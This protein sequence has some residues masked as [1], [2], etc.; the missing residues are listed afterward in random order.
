MG[1]TEPINLMTT[2]L[3]TVR[4]H[5]VIRVSLRAG[6]RW[7]KTARSSRTRRSRQ[8]TS[9]RG[10]G[11]RVECCRQP[12]GDAS[13]NQPK[14]CTTKSAFDRLDRTQYARWPSSPIS[15][16]MGDGSTFR[17][18]WISFSG[19]CCLRGSVTFRTWFRTTDLDNYPSHTYHLW[20]LLSKNGAIECAIIL[21]T[22]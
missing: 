22:L 15:S 17:R 12:D 3:R 8:V 13:Q 18:W 21:Q 7:R 10:T 19:S 5:K 2:E 20:K 4:R 9:R 14:L 16:A 1:R 6:H 11:P